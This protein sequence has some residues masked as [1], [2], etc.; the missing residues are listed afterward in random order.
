MK[1]SPGGLL[2]FY[3]NLSIRN[4][5]A[6]TL[7]AQILIPL[8]L[9]GYLSYKNSES[10]I[11]ENSTNYSRDILNMIR[12]RLDDY[13]E[14]LTKISQDLLYEDKIYDTLKR[15]SDSEDPLRQ[16]EYESTVNSHLKMVVIS[17]PE[18]RSLCI[19]ANDGRAYYQDDNT[20]EAGLRQD[21]PYPD[22]LERARLMKGKPYVHTVSENK[23]VKAIYLVR[24]IN[25]RDD[26]KELG[27]LVMKIKT[28][29]LGEVYQGLTGNLQNIVILSPDM[30]LIAGRNSDDP[31][32]YSGLLS[33]KINGDAG[34]RVDEGAGLFVSYI[35]LKSTGWKVAAYVALD[36]LYKDANT[37]RRN[38]IM[39]CF[40]VI[41]VLTV[42]TMF[43]AFDIV[44]PINQLVKGMKKVQAG[45]SNVRVEVDRGDE[46][47]FLNKAFN[48]MSGEI[49]HLVNWVYREQLT[50]K[51]AELKAL[52]SQINPHFLFNTLEAINWLAQLN[53]VPEI[54]NT[55]SDLSDL[56]E[57]SIGRD[58][59]L[60]TL[61]EEITYADKYISLQK[62][63]FGDRLELIK[64]VQPEVEGIKIPR[65][66]I[67]PLI[68]NAVYHG[69]ERIRGKG[70]ITLNAVKRGNCV[71]IEVVDNG[72][73]MEREELEQLNSRLSMDSGTYF[74]NLGDKKS[75][76]IGIENVNRRIKLFY[77]ESYGLKIDSEAG[78]FTKAAVSIPFKINAENGE[79]FYVQSSDH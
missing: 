68:E 9:I 79:D 53:H 16:F 49:N 40:I 41:L 77:G 70:V 8:V 1:Y 47:G 18:I 3:K 72:A 78:K 44:K 75:R 39:L 67:Q 30:D 27:L 60:I 5:L 45:E 59:R 13:L 76:S 63:R 11:K 20:K 12:L 37:L 51:E 38:I 25:D 73:G 29:L 74:K 2:K 21:I 55:V 56:M 6:L 42:L 66:L 26:F 7:F 52:Q 65:L 23:K 61:K 58:D 32:V 69:I 64:N 15:S 14:N 71:S 57:G 19:F 33:D 48:E 43:I 17:R 62:R 54:R 34:E 28:E 4:K 36:E 31:T 10:I 50:R 24:Q 46:L 35:T 22:M